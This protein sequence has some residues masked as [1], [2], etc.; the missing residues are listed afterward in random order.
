MWAGG[1]KS[2][3]FLWICVA[4]M[5]WL[6]LLFFI[7]YW[8]GMKR[9]YTDFS[10]LYTAGTILR[11]GLGH[12]LYDRETQLR[13]QE[14]FTGHLPFRR[15]PLPYIHP[16]FEAP[17]FVPLA[18][19]GYEQAFVVWDFLT[20]CTLFGV[21]LLLRQSVPILSQV[22]PWKFVLGA[23]AFYPVFTCFLQ[24][25]D[26]ILQLLFCAAGFQALRKK[27]DF[28]A[29][30]CFALA[31]FKFQFMIP[32]VC[33]LAVWG[34]RRT[35]VGFAAIAAVL[36]LVSLG[37]V[38]GD[39]LWHYPKYALQIVEAPGLGGV[40]LALMPN[41]HG[42]AAG[43]A[44]PLSR[45]M[46]LVLAII[47]STLV[48]VFAAWRGRVPASLASLEL[49][50]SLALVVSVLIGW[51]T[52][53]HD[54]SLLVIALALLAD[55]CF[56]TGPRKS[57]LMLLLPA[58]PLLITPLWM[59]LWLSVAKVNL[60]AIPMLWWVWVIGKE[61]SRVARNSFPDSA[62]HPWQSLDTGGKKAESA[63]LP[64]NS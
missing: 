15:G 57:G 59:V 26:S 38:G 44:G 8:H 3:R 4:A 49:Q 45:T 46:G 7:D 40:P 2:L 62:M 58:V 20:L 64:S 55:Y 63:Q 19:L 29:G 35:A 41:L 24:G 36:A 33:L 12:Q 27:A 52:N 37:I 5:L 11:E 31:A 18:F 48:V 25:Q 53:A 23:L 21:G 9:G 17:I 50:V 61:L 22:P 30:C 6:H 60:M 28:F 56:S 32:L 16:P 43:W 42:L 47:A 13:V 54:L 39:A 1:A 14:S 51:Q 10:V 34:R